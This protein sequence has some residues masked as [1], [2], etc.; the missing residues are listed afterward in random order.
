M[1]KQERGCGGRQR[2]R[3]E[4]HGEVASRVVDVEGNKR[5]ASVGSSNGRLK[6]PQGAIDLAGNLDQCQPV[7]PEDLRMQEGEDRKQ[8]EGQAEDERHG[9]QPSIRYRLGRALSAMPF[10]TLL[11]GMEKPM[12]GGPIL[13]QITPA[14]VFVLPA[15][16]SESAHLFGGDRLEVYGSDPEPFVLGGF[17]H[18]FAFAVMIL[19][20]L[21]LRPEH[22]HRFG[23]AFAKEQPLGLPEADG[24]G[25][26]GLPF[27]KAVICRASFS[28]GAWA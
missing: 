26:A 27:S 19:S 12:L 18:Q 2:H 21:L 4:G 8:G 17:G 28:T 24:G 20:D 11:T 3:G 14:V 6:L 16:V 5:P 25:F 1:G 23:V 22:L 10:R 7:A 15:V 13:G 9:R